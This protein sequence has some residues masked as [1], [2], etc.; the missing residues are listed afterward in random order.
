MKVS[1]IIP[2]LNEE[3]NILT[4]LLSIKKQQ[5]DFEIIVVDGG[6]TDR[7]AEIARPH[8]SVISSERGRAVQMNAGA[9]LASGEILLFLHADSILHPDALSNLNQALKDP[10]NVGGTFTLKFDSDKFLLRF[11]TFFTRFKFRYFHYGDQGIFVRR[12]VFE[13]LGGFKEIPI[14][15]DIDFLRRMHGRGRVA[16]IKLPVT[17][18]ARRFLKR[19]LFRQQ[20]LNTILVSLYVLGVKPETLSRWYL[21]E[22]ATSRL[23]RIGFKAGESR[24]DSPVN[25]ESASYQKPD[26]D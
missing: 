21:P 2:A 12:S 18:S 7:T 20:L 25:T 5:G 10:E 13:Q 23:R 1:V 8:A 11:Y 22:P 4:T 14:M 17:T 15:E 26:Y 19:G 9:R 6:S 16:L 24:F 3:R